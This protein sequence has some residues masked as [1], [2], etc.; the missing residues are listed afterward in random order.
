MRLVLCRDRSW[1]R[2]IRPTRMRRGRGCGGIH[3][4]V[5]GVGMHVHAVVGG[6]QQ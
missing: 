5:C 1:G 3:G 4:E 6:Y 2:E